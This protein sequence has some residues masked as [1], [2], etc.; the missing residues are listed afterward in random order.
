[1]LGICQLPL[2]FACCYTNLKSLLASR[3]KNREA[4]FFVGERVKLPQSFGVIG[5]VTILLVL[6]ISLAPPVRQKTVMQHSCQG[7]AS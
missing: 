6:F 3:P 7:L 4:L 1:M 2:F 5:H